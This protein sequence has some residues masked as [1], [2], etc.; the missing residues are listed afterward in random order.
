MNVFESNPVNELKIRNYN[1]EDMLAYFNLNEKEGFDYYPISVKY[2]SLEEMKD[3]LKLLLKHDTLY[4][5][6]KNKSVIGFC[7][8][9]YI[10]YENG[11][12]DISIKF[13][14]DNFPNNLYVN[15][16]KLVLHLFFDIFN[17]N[18]VS[19]KVY[20]YEITLIKILEQL[21]IIKYATLP[22]EIYRS[23]KS[24]SKFIYSI[25]RC[26]YKNLLG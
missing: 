22:D 16:V 24:Y 17:L 9:E 3:E 19:I 26:E 20:E 10:R 15:S 8:S 7:R 5:I 21:K 6:E 1:D 14:S 13:V 25:F 23:N 11:T 18:K 4:V 12:V 2:A